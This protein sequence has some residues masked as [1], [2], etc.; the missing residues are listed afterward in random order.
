M[1]FAQFGALLSP[2]AVRNA[3]RRRFGIESSY[4]Q[5]R[6]VRIKTNS[7]NPALRF[8]YMALALLLVN[9][10]CLLRFRHCQRPR[11]G[12]TGRPVDGRTFK[13]RHLALFL[14]TAIERHR[15]LAD[16][17]RA[18]ALPLHAESVVH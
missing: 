2:H 4:R 15:G 6:Q 13:L 17:I 14:R 5:L 1:V 8:V 9:L 12:C 18:T 7:R 11:R 3:Y 16:S 10:W